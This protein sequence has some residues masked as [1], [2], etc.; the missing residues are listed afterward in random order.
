MYI[1]DANFIEMSAEKQ[2]GTAKEGSS[3]TPRTLPSSLSSPTH[4][5]RLE[6]IM[7][8]DPIFSLSKESPS[9]LPAF[10]QKVSLLQL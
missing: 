3:S 8:G 5:H 9:S 6:P 7:N 2:L 1:S 10:L 4:D